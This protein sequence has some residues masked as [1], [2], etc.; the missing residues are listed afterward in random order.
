M[1]SYQVFLMYLKLKGVFSKIHNVCFNVTDNLYGYSEKSG[2]YEKKSVTFNKVFLDIFKNYGFCS[3]MVE[4]VLY[5][6]N[7][8]YGKLGDDDIMKA[9]RRWNYFIKNNVVL[10]NL[11]VGDTLTIERFGNICTGEVISIHRDFSRVVISDGDRKT[12]VRSN[13]IKEVN[14][15]P[16]EFSFHIN[17]KGKE[18]GKKVT[19]NS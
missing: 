10:D 19:S 8:M 16:F 17:V 12:Y 6:F 4:T 14:G 11:K 15:K 1:S 13:N 7:K 18:Y 5:S 3:N 2:M 9:S